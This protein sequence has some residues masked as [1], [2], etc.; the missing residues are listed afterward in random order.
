MN[1]YDANEYQPEL[2]NYL[3]KRILVKIQA[4]RTISGVLSGYDQYMNLVLDEAIDMN[5][6]SS[7][8]QILLRGN[9]ILSIQ[10]I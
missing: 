4:K 7:I 2:K 6:Q 8:G 1:K 3:H 5:T 9:A 10:T